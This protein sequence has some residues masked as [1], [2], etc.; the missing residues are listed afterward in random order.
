[1]RVVFP[2]HV[3]VREQNLLP[4]RLVTLAVLKR[5]AFFAIPLPANGQHPVG[6]R[7]AKRWQNVAINLVMNL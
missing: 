2:K 5:E 7:V 6:V 3:N 4:C 1:M